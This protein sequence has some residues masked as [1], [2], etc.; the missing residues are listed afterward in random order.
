MRCINLKNIIREP[1]D[2]PLI[3]GRT[4]TLPY[5]LKGISK[6]YEAVFRALSWPKY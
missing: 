5:Q 2:A 3:G 1:H 4:G 6:G